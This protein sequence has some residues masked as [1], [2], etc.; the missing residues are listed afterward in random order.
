L[1]KPTFCRSAWALLC[2]LTLSFPFASPA[3]QSASAR[4]IG[5][6]TDPSGKVVQHVAVTLTNLAQGTTRS[7]STQDDGSFSFTTLEAGSYKL[8]V[9]APTGFTPYEQNVTVN[10][11]QELSVPVQL[12][13]ASSQVKIEIAADTSPAVN[14]TTSALGGVINARQISTLP[15]N[16]RNYLELSLLVPGNAP[17]RT[18][19][20]P[21]RI[22]LSSPLP[23]RLAGGT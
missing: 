18:S 1:S 20:R 22:R 10:V 4:I 13:I 2:V 6:V 3:L 11:G 9:D 21:R 23:V 5:V 8:T 12:E 19:I 14:T 16:G 15:L 7:F 17:V